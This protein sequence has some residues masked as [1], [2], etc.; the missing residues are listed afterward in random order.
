[1]KAVVLMTLILAVIASACMAAETHMT[2]QTNTTIRIDP[3]TG[4][5]KGGANTQIKGIKIDPPPPTT[6]PAGT[7]TTST[8]P[9]TASV[10]GT[11]STDTTVPSTTTAGTSSSSPAFFCPFAQG[12]GGQSN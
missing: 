9:S 7:T 11:S 2:I 5:I 6:S 4:D 3:I 12:S 8:D 10:S 1:M